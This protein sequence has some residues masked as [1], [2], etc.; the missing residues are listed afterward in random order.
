MTEALI[1]NPQ[2]M[3][4][5]LLWNLALIPSGLQL[6]LF[7]CIGGGLTPDYIEPVRDICT[8]TVLSALAIGF[9]SLAAVFAAL[10]P[11]TLRRWF[12][13][14]RWSAT[15]MLCY[16]AVAMFV[17]V[18][19]RPRASYVFCFSIEIMALTVL[20]LRHL[21][22]S[23]SLDAWLRRCAPGL[24]L[25]AIL[26][27]PSY[28]AQQNAERKLLNYI[29]FLQPFALVIEYDHGQVLM[30]SYVHEIAHYLYG[31]NVVPFET[32]FIAPEQIAELSR[33]AANY[34]RILNEHNVRDVMFDQPTHL[35]PSAAEQAVKSAPYWRLLGLR[36]L[37]DRTLSLYSK[38]ELYGNIDLQ[39]RDD[40]RVRSHQ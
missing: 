38:S 20:S 1:R 7:N 19:Q 31:T 23:P 35:G 3:T 33:P 36:R 9:I 40:S 17:M 26:V 29:E 2:I 39:D 14:H 16:A 28:Y 30:P 25:C 27:V 37:P 34:V 15:A 8:A 18:M 32:R 4:E 24:M 12:A 6:M 21:V 5:H 22:T 13:A 11:L 10:N